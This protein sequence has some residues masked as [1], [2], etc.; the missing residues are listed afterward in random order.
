VATNLEKVAIRRL[1][2]VGVASLEVA[3]SHLEAVVAALL[4]DTSLRS[5]ES[6]FGKL[7]ALNG[8]KEWL[9]SGWI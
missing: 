2:E 7:E 8:I 3:V 5:L 4:E 1:E 6:H 9:T